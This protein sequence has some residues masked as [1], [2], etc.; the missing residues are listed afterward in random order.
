MDN[1]VTT[2]ED[3]SSL[4]SKE[5]RC[6]TK[7]PLCTL[8]LLLLVDC[9]QHRPTDL[10]LQ[11]LAL[12]M[13]FRV[14]YALKRLVH[15]KHDIQACFERMALGGFLFDNT[16]FH[17]VLFFLKCIILW[18]Q[19]LCCIEAIQRLLRNPNFSNQNRRHRFLKLRAHLV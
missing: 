15:R 13:K 1:G 2:F 14:I 18:Q 19:K 8:G 9:L 4:A 5:S 6:N 10:L 17:Y 16:K 3:P 7:K 12:S 11:R